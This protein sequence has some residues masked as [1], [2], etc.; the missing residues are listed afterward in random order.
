M[1]NVDDV[2]GETVPHVID[3]LIARGAKSVHVV[4]AITKKGRPEFIFLLT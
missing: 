4:P 1:V 2:S 3:G